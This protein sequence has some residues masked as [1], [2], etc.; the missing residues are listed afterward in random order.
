ML[1]TP[2]PSSPVYVEMT[3][4]DPEPPPVVESKILVTRLFHWIMRKVSTFLY[5]RYG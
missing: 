3:R 4:E 1:Q 5:N 2:R